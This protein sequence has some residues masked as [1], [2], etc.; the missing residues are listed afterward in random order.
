MNKTIQEKIDSNMLLLD[1]P[2]KQIK[3]YTKVSKWKEQ[4]N[5]IIDL[6]EED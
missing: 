2:N 6:L 1:I 4:F 5:K 3:G